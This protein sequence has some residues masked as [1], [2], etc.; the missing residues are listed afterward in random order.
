MNDTLKSLPIPR[1]S[2][3]KGRGSKKHGNNKGKCQKYRMLGRKEKNK[4]RKKITQRNKEEKKKQK[5]I[6]RKQ[7]KQHNETS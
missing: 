4:A 7:R 2:R 5:L 3:T 1:K 6:L